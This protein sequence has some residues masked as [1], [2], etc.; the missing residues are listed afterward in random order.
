MGTQLGYLWYSASSRIS[1]GARK[2]QV[3]VGAGGQG[4]VERTRRVRARA[5]GTGWK[6]VACARPRMFDPTKV[7]SANAKRT[8]NDLHFCAA[9]HTSFFCFFLDF[10]AL[11]RFGPEVATSAKH[12]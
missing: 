1:C 3:Q 2:H 9:F 12:S 8:C 4:P 6:Q 5:Q 10:V 7:R 11:P